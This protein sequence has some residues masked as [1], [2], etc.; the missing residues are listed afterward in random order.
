MV[1]AGTYLSGSTPPEIPARFKNMKKPSIAEKLTESIGTMT[2][3]IAVL[4]PQVRMV[5]I[6]EVEVVLVVMQVL[7]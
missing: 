7:V 6:M 4:Y 3:S 5:L 1:L 2:S